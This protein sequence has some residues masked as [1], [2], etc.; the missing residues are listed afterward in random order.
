MFVLPSY[1]ES[2]GLVILEALASGLP[3]IVTPVGC[4][5]EVIEPGVNGFLVTRDPAD[6]GRR[7]E[8]LAESDVGAYA[9]AAVA[10]VERHDWRAVAEQYVALLQRI[11]AEPRRA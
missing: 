5:S 4:A 8:Q 11:A 6:I 3:V 1:Y 7:M 9:S 2:H 10:S